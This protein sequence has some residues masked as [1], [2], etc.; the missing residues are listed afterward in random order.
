MLRKLFL[1]ILA[2][3][4]FGYVRTR[5]LVKQIPHS[6]TFNSCTYEH[7]SGS[8]LNLHFF[9]MKAKWN[10]H[11]RSTGN[12]SVVT[13]NGNAVPGGETLPR[14]TCI[15]IDTVE[16][17]STQNQPFFL[18]ILFLHKHSLLTYVQSSATYKAG[19]FFVAS[20]FLLF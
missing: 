19:K 1:Q 17:C 7:T 6:F 16:I 20:I 18:H 15:I 5:A 11:L 9:Q 4:Y 2:Y 3:L 10:T 12:Q 14:Q 13:T 8:N